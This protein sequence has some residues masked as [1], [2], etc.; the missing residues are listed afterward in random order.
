MKGAKHICRKAGCG[1]LIAAG[2]YCDE[3]KREARK[4]QDEARGTANDRGYSAA[5]RK[6]R[7][8][9]LRKHPLC[10]RCLHSVPPVIVAA[11]VVDH[12]IP[13]R[14]DKDLFWDR[15]NWQSLCKPCHDEKTA[16]EDGGFS[17]YPGYRKVYGRVA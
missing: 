17:G 9:F 1:R 15:N 6:A 13:H 4:Q 3:H 14:G 16:R 2:G 11:T 5:W 7:E 12:I 10:V 8:G